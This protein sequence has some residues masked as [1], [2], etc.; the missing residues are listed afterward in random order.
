ME[1]PFCFSEQHFTEVVG[2]EEFLNLGM[3]QV[4]SLI[5]SD[6]LT[7]PTEEKVH[8]L[9]PL[10]ALTGQM[11]V[12]VAMRAL[13]CL[14]LIAQVFEAV[15]AWVNHDKDVRQEHLAHLM[16][17]VRLPLLSREYLVQVRAS[18]IGN[19]VFGFRSACSAWLLLA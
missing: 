4:S 17:H 7:I 12:P 19:E 10:A 8:R 18:V 6:K 3:E 15:I 1:L 14:C 13:V 11:V 5:A 9:A 2:S 16:E